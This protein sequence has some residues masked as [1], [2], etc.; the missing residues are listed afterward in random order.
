MV[1]VQFTLIYGYLL[2][3]GSSCICF[4]YSYVKTLKWCFSIFMP[5]DNIVGNMTVTLC[6]LLKQLIFKKTWTWTAWIGWSLLWLLRKNFPSK[7]LMTKQISLLAVLTLQNT[8]ALELTRKLWK[9]PDFSV[10]TVIVGLRACAIQDYFSFFFLV[11]LCVSLPSQLGC[12]RMLV[13][14]LVA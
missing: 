3:L 1:K 7:S 14:R 9:R 10:V 11:E 6:R 2:V 13:D 8:L 5:K 4:H 12:K